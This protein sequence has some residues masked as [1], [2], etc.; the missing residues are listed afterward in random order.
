MAIIIFYNHLWHQIKRHFTAVTA[1]D[2]RSLL[3]EDWTSSEQTSEWNVLLHSILPGGGELPVGQTDG[4]VALG[5]TTRHSL[6]LTRGKVSH[7]RPRRQRLGCSGI[8]TANSLATELH[9]KQFTETKAS[10]R[11]K[12][13]KISIN[14]H[15]TFLSGVKVATAGWRTV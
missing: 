13:I 14:G 11:G 1:T 12:T 7:P 4:I 9:L 3:I 10:S 5:I 15:V 2:F 8:R 6:T